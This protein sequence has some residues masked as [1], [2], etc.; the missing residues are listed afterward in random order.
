MKVLF[1]IAN[2]GYQDHEYQKTKEILEN[3]GIKV[4]TTAKNLG[5]AK[6]K[7]N[8]QTKIDLTLDEVNVNN[9]DAIIFIGGPGAYSYQKDESAH[10][11]AKEAINK[12][13]LLAA[14]C[15]APTILAYAGVLKNKNATVWNGD[16]K[17]EILFKE[18]NINYTGDT[19]T[20]DGNI[21]T[22]NGPPTAEEFAKTILQKISS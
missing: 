4:F 18:L 7:F 6:G 11:L 3:S 8:S 17:Q 12:N 10:K 14:I 19:V 21:I 5:V 20:I 13:K 1:I 2:V 16:G 9:Y 15:I 22:A